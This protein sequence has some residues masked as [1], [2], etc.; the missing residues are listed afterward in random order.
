MCISATSSFV[1]AGGLTLVGAATL[2]RT[3]YAEHRMLAALPFFFAI[4][5]A[6]EGIV[7]LTLDAR[8]WL[9]SFGAYGF[10]FFAFIFFPLYVPL[11]IRRFEKVP[12]RQMLL[13]GITLVGG[14][15]G[16][17][18][19]YGMIMNGVV[20]SV[21]NHHISYGLALA[22][23]DTKLIGLAACSIVF[24]GSLYASSQRILWAAGLGVIGLVAYTYLAVPEAVVS[25][26]CFLAGV[27]SILL[28][29]AVPRLR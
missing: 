29:W 26:W 21:V 19:L 27:L 13:L 18:V 10:L 15:I 1:V 25:M 3:R 6:L 20:A 23:G 11:S 7:W 2:R 5:Q 17:A 28:W 22:G 12:W 4:Q 8:T 16:L 24:V 14:G 9:H